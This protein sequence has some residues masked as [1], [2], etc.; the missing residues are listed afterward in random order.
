MRKANPKTKRP[1]D[2]RQARERAYLKTIAFL[3]DALKTPY[4]IID[5]ATLKNLMIEWA[6]PRD[7]PKVSERAFNVA[8]RMATSGMPI[9]VNEVSRLAE[10]HSKVTTRNLIRRLRDAGCIIMVHTNQKHGFD[11][12]VYRTT[13]KMPA[14]YEQ[15]Q[16]MEKEV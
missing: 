16:A 14:T 8:R 15:F 3:D 12:P 1:R 2:L 10:N 7:R 6:E 11:E 5:A 4:A 9:S 13:K